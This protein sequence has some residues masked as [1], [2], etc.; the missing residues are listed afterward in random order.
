MLTANELIPIVRGVVRP[1]IP[2]TA[3]HSAMLMKMLDK[4][5]NG[6]VT[7]DEFLEG[8]K[9]FNWNAE[10]LSDLVAKSS[11]RPIGASSGDLSHDIEIPF[12]EIMFG[13]R[14]GEGTFGLVFKAHWRG[15]P[16]AVKMLKMQNI[17]EHALQEFRKE[18]QILTRLRHPNI[19]LLMGASTIPP[20]LTFVTEFLSGGS[21]FDQLQAKKLTVDPFMFKRMAREIAQGMN[22]LHL[23]GIIHRDLKSLNILL[24]H[25]NTVKICDFGLSKMRA[26]EA[27]VM[28]KKIGTP[29]WMAPELIRGEDYNEKVDVYAFGIILWELGTGELPYPKMDSIQIA[30]AVS[31]KGM[32][33]P[34][35]DKWPPF[36]REL[37]Q[38]CW[39][40]DHKVRPTFQQILDKLNQW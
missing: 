22:Y 40:D 30:V 20:N 15:S 9:K 16:V 5:G 35:P 39:H 11:Q 6:T 28:T 29:I 23:S 25:N 34:I 14:I 10:V 4:D 17:T 27:D 7:I 13:D 1:G 31:S 33:P 2:V 12:N 36:L 3:Q 32:R 19:V 18:L 37:A 24:D 21:L 38:A 8:A 26:S